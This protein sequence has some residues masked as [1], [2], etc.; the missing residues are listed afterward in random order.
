MDYRTNFVVDD[1]W[2][3]EAFPGEAN[4]QFPPLTS[5]TCMNKKRAHHRE[6]R[7]PSKRR[8]KSLPVVDDD[9][10]WIDALMDAWSPKQNLSFEE[11]ARL[12]SYH[13]EDQQETSASSIYGGKEWDSSSQGTTITEPWGAT[14]GHSNTAQEYS[15]NSSGSNLDDSS[16]QS[17]ILHSDHGFHSR[18]ISQS[19]LSDSGH[20]PSVEPVS[21]YLTGP[22]APSR[23]AMSSIASAVAALTN[24]DSVEEIHPGHASTMLKIK[25]S[26]EPT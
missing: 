6:D 22:G 11:T 24:H 4:L 10:T 12:V 14:H 21:F 23:P 26:N 16:S 15:E 8:R 17:G 9:S 5:G 7:F 20:E 13:P 2:H 18:I 19:Q 3:L 1:S 25:N